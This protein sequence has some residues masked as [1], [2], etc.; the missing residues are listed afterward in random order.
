MSLPVPTVPILAPVEAEHSR[1]VRRAKTLSWLSCGAGINRRTLGRTAPLGLRAAGQRAGP[2]GQPGPRR[3]AG[4][5]RVLVQRVGTVCGLQLDGRAGPQLRTECPVLPPR[6]RRDLA[7]RCLAASPA[8][9]PDTAT[10]GDHGRHRDGHVRA[11]HLVLHQ[12]AHLALAAACAHARDWLLSTTTPSPAEPELTT[13]AE[14]I[15]T[16]PDPSRSSLTA[17]PLD[18]R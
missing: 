5:G 8:A 18:D 14:T 10:R 6:D 11:G 4:A 12:H 17:R 3:G 15:P 1:L 13:P 9:A 7:A 2:S 16:H